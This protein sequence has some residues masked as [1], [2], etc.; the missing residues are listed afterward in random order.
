MQLTFVV[1]RQFT[2]F[3]PKKTQVVCEPVTTP[4]PLTNLILV[5]PKDSVDIPE[6]KST[7]DITVQP[8]GY[9]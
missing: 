4:S 2:G 7:L 3:D 5:Y 6:I 1:V 9:K 8:T